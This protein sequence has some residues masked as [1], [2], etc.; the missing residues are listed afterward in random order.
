M[1]DPHFDQAGIE[2][3]K[4]LLSTFSPKKLQRIAICV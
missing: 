2:K 3:P 4:R 1:A